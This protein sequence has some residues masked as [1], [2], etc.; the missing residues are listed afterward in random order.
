MANT[1][2]DHKF[3]IA[4]LIHTVRLTS[5]VLQYKKVKP[6]SHCQDVTHNVAKCHT[7]FFLTTQ[8]KKE[9]KKSCCRL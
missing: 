6:A 1:Q 5:L 3:Y 8:S 7:K 9:K 2:N 4:L